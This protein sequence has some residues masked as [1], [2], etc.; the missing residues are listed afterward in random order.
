MGHI[1]TYFDQ[2]AE[3]AFGPNLCEQWH[4]EEIGPDPRQHDRPEEER[5]KRE[6]ELQRA[7]EK[8]RRRDHDS[9]DQRE[10]FRYREEVQG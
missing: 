3:I 7:E 9:S 2:V 6:E 10:R 1:D 4:E 8:Q 5:A